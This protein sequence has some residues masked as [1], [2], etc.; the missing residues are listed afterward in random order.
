M[1]LGTKT[2]ELIGFYGISTTAINLIVPPPQHS[3]LL[4]TSEPRSVSSQV[5]T[6]NMRIFSVKVC[7]LIL[8][9]NYYQAL[10]AHSATYNEILRMQESIAECTLNIARANFRSGSIIAIVEAGLR[11]HSTGN[12]SVDTNKLILETIMKEMKWNIQSFQVTSYEEKYM[13]RLL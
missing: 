6:N 7:V 11:D 2:L 10:N 1:Y 12:W 8:Y 3:I 13:V 9:A 5:S 4:L